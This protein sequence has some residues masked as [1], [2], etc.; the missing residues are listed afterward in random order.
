MKDLLQ[1]SRGIVTLI[2][3][4]LAKYKP[5]ETLGLEQRIGNDPSFRNGSRSIVRKPSSEQFS[6]HSKKFFSLR[7]R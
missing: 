7:K 3:K 6:G 1:K 2:A 4:A 5:T